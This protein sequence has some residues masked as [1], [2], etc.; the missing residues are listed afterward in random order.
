ML[1]I[2]AMK[3]RLGATQ[4]RQVACAS[5]ITE[6]SESGRIVA[7]FERC[8]YNKASVI[9]Q[10]SAHSNLEYNHLEI[11]DEFLENPIV[12]GYLLLFSK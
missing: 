7:S 8:S 2:A 10:R 11:S 5:S 3:S 6:Y 9:S 12:S 4:E 1:K